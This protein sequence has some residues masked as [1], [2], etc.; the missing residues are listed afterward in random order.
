MYLLQ[1][2]HVDARVADDHA[3]EHVAR[4][5]GRRGDRQAHLRDGRLR[6]VKPAAL[7][8]ELRPGPR[9]VDLH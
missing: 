6:R 5:A 1:V 3:D 8:R 2:Q 4:L 9:R 7:R